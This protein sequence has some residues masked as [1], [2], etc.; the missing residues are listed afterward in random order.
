MTTIGWWVKQRTRELGLR[1]ALGATRGT[2]TGLVFRQGLAI[3]VVGIVVGCAI[4]AGATR[5]LQGWIYG[6][7]PLD[8]KTFVA[9]CAGMLLVAVLA[10]SLPVRRATSV[11]PVVALRTE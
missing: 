10:I 9:C 1:I 11:D 2:V 3:A 5:Y 6:V 8:P 7:T 4:A